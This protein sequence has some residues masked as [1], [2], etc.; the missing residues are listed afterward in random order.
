MAGTA[1]WNVITAVLWRR[2]EIVRLCIFRRLLLAIITKYTV[3]WEFQGIQ[4][5]W[6]KRRDTSR[7]PANATQ[8]SSVFAPDLKWSPKSIACQLQAWN[9]ATE[10]FFS[11]WNFECYM[12][13]NQKIQFVSDKKR[14]A[15]EFCG[16]VVFPLLGCQVCLLSGFVFVSKWNLPSWLHQAEDAGA[17]ASASGRVRFLHSFPFWWILLLKLCVFAGWAPVPARTHVGGA[18]EEQ[19]E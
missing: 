9:P 18:L 3:I 19:L 4:T 13:E 5:P 2:S 6:I 12:S 8:H 14:C 15:S 10:R 16:T 17:M 1:K 11:H 7:L